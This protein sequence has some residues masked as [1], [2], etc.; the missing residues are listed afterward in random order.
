M[1]TPVNANQRVKTNVGDTESFEVPLDF[2][3]DEGD[4]KAQIAS[5][6]NKLEHYIGRAQLRINKHEQKIDQLRQK[7][8]GNRSEIDAALAVNHLDP[9]IG[10]DA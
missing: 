9:T 5:K 7:I 2:L 6:I 1:Q 3:E 10:A 4:S 8:T